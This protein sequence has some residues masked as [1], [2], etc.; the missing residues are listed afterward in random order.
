MEHDLI[1]TNPHLKKP[2]L[3]ILGLLEAN[4]PRRRDELEREAAEKHWR[5][6]FRHSPAAV[7]D[8]LVRNGALNEQAYVNGE[9]YG[10]TLEDAQADKSLPDDA[11]AWT[12]VGLSPQGAALRDAYAPDVTVRTLF[13][14]HPRYA[15][16]FRAALWAC[17]NEGG[18]SRADLEAQIGALSPT[19]DGEPD[20]AKVYPQYFIDALESAGAIAWE[21]GTWHATP[22]GQTYAESR[23][24]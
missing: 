10:G 17:S 13:D 14:E 19:K 21:A 3:T 22:T 2:V 9:P 8:I 1:N 4:T 18:C 5:P 11:E 16:V 20:G 15:D 24:Q 12:R 7:V 23:S 6:T